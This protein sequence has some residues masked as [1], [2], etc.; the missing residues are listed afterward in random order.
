MINKKKQKKAHELFFAWK[1][2]ILVNQIGARSIYKV[3]LNNCIFIFRLRT[4]VI[5]G[6][7][8]DDSDENIS[9]MQQTQARIQWKFQRWDPSSQKGCQ[10]C[11]QKDKKCLTT[12]KTKVK[13]PIPKNS[14]KMKRNILHGYFFCLFSDLDPLS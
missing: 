12:R 8:V 14:C 13:V 6:Q 7:N 4:I 10:G 11:E 9:R 5:D 3:L 2:N 1:D